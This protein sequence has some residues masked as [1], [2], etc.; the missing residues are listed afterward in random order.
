MSDLKAAD[1]AHDILAAPAGTVRDETSAVF[2]RSLAALAKP[3]RLVLCGIAHYPGSL[4]TLIAAVPSDLPT[5]TAATLLATLSQRGLLIPRQSPSSTQAN[6][7]AD[8]H[9][10][11]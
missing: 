7:G 10:V 6:L 4:G 8:N 5:N 2:A 11:A 1:P 3:A 9:K